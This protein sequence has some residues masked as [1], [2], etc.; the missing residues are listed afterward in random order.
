MIC[1]VQHIRATIRR[2]VVARLTQF[3]GSRY[4]RSHTKWVGG[5]HST[6]IEIGEPGCSGGSTTVWHK[7]HTWKGTNSY[8]KFT[9]RSTW[10]ERVADNGLAVIDGML[11]LDAEPIP[12]AGP[13]TSAWRVV[14][15]RQSTGFSIVAETGYVVRQA[16]LDLIRYSKSAVHARRWCV[17]ETLDHLRPCRPA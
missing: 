9:V 17:R 5:E 2:L 4:R 13:G 16:G 1:D 6:T 3:L 7:K 10:C 15:A 12:D 8:H 14:L 11:C